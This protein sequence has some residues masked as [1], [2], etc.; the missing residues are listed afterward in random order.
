[1]FESR[2]RIEHPEEN[3]IMTSAT[4]TTTTT[5][6]PRATSAAPEGDFL[7]RLSVDQYRQLIGLGFFEEPGQ[8]AELLEG[9]LVRKMTKYPP[10]VLV[11]KQAFDL[12][13]ASIP[14]GWHVAKED[15]IETLDSVPEP[16]LAVIRGTAKD[17]GNRWPGP[18][19]LALV[20][21]VSDA[22]LRLDQ[23]TKRFLYAK[24]SIPFYW[25]INLKGRKVEVH[26]DPTGPADRPD[27]RQRTEYGIEDAVPLV[28]EGRE[29][30]RI[31][32]RELL[33]C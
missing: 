33:P 16:D 13:T 11:T 10:H 24:A 6:P 27:Y 20:V 18:A 9:V 3:P 5:T 32:V 4:T 17:Y 1:M 19:D 29:V 25:I 21:E 26:S 2:A 30:A 14:A 31:V 23:K 7:Y 28:I 22:S 15:P 12:L 8:K